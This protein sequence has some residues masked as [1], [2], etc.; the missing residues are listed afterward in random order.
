MIK[1]ITGDFK[2]PSD[3]RTN[4]EKNVIRKFY[5]WMTEGKQITVGASG[6]TIYVPNFQLPDLFILLFDKYHE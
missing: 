6:K 1:K 3:E 2:K 4:V 5:R